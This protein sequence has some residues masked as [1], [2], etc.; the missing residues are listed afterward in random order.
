[1]PSI[2]LLDNLPEVRLKILENIRESLLD[3]TYSDEMSDDEATQVVRQMTSVSEYILE[4]LGVE[5]QRE[6]EDGSISVLIHFQKPE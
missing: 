2:N 5:I 4:L 6:N 1:M 3:I